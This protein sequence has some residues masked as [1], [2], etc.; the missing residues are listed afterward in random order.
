MSGP[1]SQIRLRSATLTNCKCGPPSN[2]SN[3]PTRLVANIS[4]CLPSTTALQR[5]RLSPDLS[6]SYPSS[7][8]TSPGCQK[9]AW[10]PQHRIKA[11]LPPAP[12]ILH[13]I[14]QHHVKQRQRKQCPADTPRLDRK[15]G[16]ETH[17]CCRQ[18]SRP[19]RHRMYHR[20]VGNAQACALGALVRGCHPGQLVQQD[21]CRGAEG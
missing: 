4:C 16:T 13:S 12:R 20:N 9:D 19:R 2:M 21:T 10:P 18:P 6:K 5:T 1:S 8:I 15:L 14:Y 3:A 17:Y 7:L 11:P